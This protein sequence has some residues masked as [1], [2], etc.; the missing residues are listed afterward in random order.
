MKSV[1]AGM[2]VAV[3]LALPA[4][5]GNAGVSERDAWM[6]LARKGW[7]YELRSAMYRPDPDRPAVRIN[8]RHLAGA[9]IC[10]VG[11]PP[12]PATRAVLAAFRALVGDVFG[13]PMSLRLGGEALDG[14]GDARAVY[15]RLFSGGL[16]V[17]EQAR[18]I[19]WLDAAFELGIA[20]GRAPPALSPAQAQT[21]FGRRGSATY[22]LVRQPASPE[23]EPLDLRFHASILIEELFQS[24]TFGM[25]ILHFDREAPLL[26]KLEELP[27]NLRSLGWDTP[28]Y[29]E[30][31]LASNPSG[32]CRFDVFMLHA[33]AAAPVEETNSEAFLAFIEADFDDLVARTEATLAD[34]RHVLLL[35]PVC[36]RG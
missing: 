29:M 2:L 22:L 9:E 32:L 15:L 33:L 13:T 17:R 8:G 11:A 18:D 12:H 25:D 20:P 5:A 28:A 24:F 26:S 23:P 30:G 34:P 36:G 16:P 21:Y 1:L 19:A 14:C 35:D 10:V 4:A 3:G 7:V 27:V 6:A 31:L